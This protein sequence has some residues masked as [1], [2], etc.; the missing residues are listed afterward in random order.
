VK[1][2]A[3][4]AAERFLRR[5]M[6]NIGP[7]WGGLELSIGGIPGR[8]RKADLVIGPPRLRGLQGRLTPD[9]PPGVVQVRIVSSDKFPEDPGTSQG[10]DGLLW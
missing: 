8:Q 9:L 5:D 3:S 1:H 7:S 6:G 2:R 4:G 10:G